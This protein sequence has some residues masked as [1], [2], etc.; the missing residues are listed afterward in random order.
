MHRAPFIATVA[1]LA[2]LACTAPAWGGPRDRGA[3]L[4]L[5]PGGND[6][7]PCTSAAPCASLQRAFD[8]ATPGSV[9]EL[10]NGSYP[11]QELG[12]D[13][14]GLVTFKPA[15]GATVTMGGR[16]TLAGAKNV[17]LVDFNF[18]RSDPSYEL[19]F[20]ACN[21]NITL[22][23]S[24]GRRFVILEG[25]SGITFDGGSW[26]GYSNPGDED[27]AI[28]TAGATGPDRTCNGAIAGRVHDVLFDHFVFH[29]VF[30]GKTEA[31]WGGSHPD[32]FEINGNVDGVTI[33][34]SA[35]VRCQ[36]S[37]LAIYTNQGNVSNVT[38]EH[39]LFKDLGDTT[40]YGSQW[41][42]DDSTGRTCGNIA[43]RGNLWLPNNPHG[44]YAFSS[45]R[46]ECRPAPGESPVQIVGNLFMAPPMPDDC[47][48]MT[49]APF[50]TV[51]RGNLFLMVS[52]ARP[53]CVTR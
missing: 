38:V 33:R 17:K 31:Q 19:L 46:S 22:Q 14:G 11:E 35:F 21:A 7:G 24:T 44:Q 42:S 1:A 2:L 9:V 30:W 6:A 49:A 36:D 10:Q 39:T 34:N 37:F 12:G 52:A 15:R 27:S 43:F 25:N 32:C 48:T 20:D 13:R 40:W 26:G 53:P 5:S 41:L 4:V 18:P 23:N 16:L 47:A 28:G 8:L 3:P 51:W 50:G 29:D 45:I